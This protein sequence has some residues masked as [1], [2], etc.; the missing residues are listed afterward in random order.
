MN[1]IRPNDD[2]CIIVSVEQFID[3]IGI[4]IKLH[5]MKQKVSTVIMLSNQHLNNSQK[6]EY[7]EI[8]IESFDMKPDSMRNEMVELF[9]LTSSILNP[10][11]M[12]IIPKISRTKDDKSLSFASDDE[13]TNHSNTS[14]QNAFN[15]DKIFK[16][17]SKGVLIFRDLV[18]VRYIHD[19]KDGNNENQDFDKALN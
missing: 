7:Y 18:L 3:P 15:V 6:T 2:E 5:D 4:H 9:S 14:M 19:T 17:K 16:E 11:D 8:D 12:I 1:Y 13:R 10:N